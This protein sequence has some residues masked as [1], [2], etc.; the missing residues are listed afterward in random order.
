VPDLQPAVLLA[1][2]LGSAVAGFLA[3]TLLLRYLQNHST[4]IFIAYRIGLAA[5]IVIWVLLG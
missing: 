3:V 5:F 4:A 1:G 2:V